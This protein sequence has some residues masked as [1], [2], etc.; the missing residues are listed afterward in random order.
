MYASIIDSST[1]A[2][3][4]VV[5]GGPAGLAAALCL[6]KNGVPVK[7]IEKGKTPEVR[8][9]GTGLWPRTMEVFAN[10][11]VVDPFLRN[12]LPVNQMRAYASNG[13]DVLKT[14]DFYAIDEPTPTSPYARALLNPQDSTEAFLRDALEK[15]GIHVE[16]GT[17]F[18]DFEQDES[19]VTVKLL[20]HSSEPPVSETF[21]ASWLLGSDGGKSAVRKRLGASFLGESENLGPMAIFGDFEM[22]NLDR[23]FWHVWGNMETSQALILPLSTPPSKR[24]QII[25]MGKNIRASESLMHGDL[26]VIQ[27]MI[28]RTTG[29]N[30]LI[31]TKAYGLTVWSP[32]IRMVNAFS[33]DRVFLIGDAAHAHPPTGAQGMNSSVQDA[34]NLGW[35]LALVHK[36]L[37]SESFLSTYNTERLPV[38]AEMLNLTK[39]ISHMFRKGDA[40]A[41]SE[42]KSPPK[43]WTRSNKLNMMGLHCHWSPIVVD[44]RTLF[45]EGGPVDVY[46]TAGGILRA[47]DRAPSA[48]GLVDI[49][50]QDAET[51]LF[52]L[53]GPAHHTA[54]V[55]SSQDGDVESALLQELD[56][57]NAI[58]PKDLSPLVL[59]VLLLPSSFQRHAAKAPA[60]DSIVRKLVD[61]DGIARG[62]YDIQQDDGLWV[63]IV[64][65]DGVVGGIVRGSEGI[66][67]YFS[68]IFNTSN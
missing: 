35:K 67:K 57:Y 58:A 20:S 23:G 29:R 10:L 60:P 55:F 27:D 31:I 7:I 47:G 66:K 56:A 34:H 65:P 53:F 5:G 52:G 3:A 44:E 37:A 25:F 50:T 46:G 4:L 59:P 11:G 12:G 1:L 26:P 45:T 41:A 36:K 17:E 6:A 9:R 21:R 28:N 39:E 51:T 42:D 2:P 33:K 68:R 64:R 24:W 38:I 40:D 63:V 61:R 14:W 48:P 49:A 19:G 22:E 15:Y 43:G 13:Y 18:V 30:D 62:A 8:A 16:F 32:N 54:L